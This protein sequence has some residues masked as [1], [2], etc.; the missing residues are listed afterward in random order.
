MKF[1]TSIGSKPDVAPDV[2][3]RSAAPPAE[4]SQAAYLGLLLDA[5]L[6]TRRW[7]CGIFA[8]RMSPRARAHARRSP[9]EANEPLP[10]SAPVT[11]GSGCG[12]WH[13][14]PGPLHARTHRAAPTRRST[15]RFA[16]AYGWFY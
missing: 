5:A 6:G 9:N 1:T 16:D 12:A 11:G 7:G 4:S 3:A 2:I 13:S 15:R 14:R 8:S 10:A